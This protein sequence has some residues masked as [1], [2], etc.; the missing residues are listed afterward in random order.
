MIDDENDPFEEIVRQFFGENNGARP[1]A[2]RSKFVENEEESREIDF[3]E[4]D[5]KTFVVFELAGYRKEDV[6]VVVEDSEIIVVA[7]RKAEESVPGYL[8][9]KLNRGI[10]IKKTL[11][12]F[13]KNKKFTWTVKN[14]ILEVIFTK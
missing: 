11:P 3:L 6:R 4:T 7:R 9:E 10:E 8:S 13:L 2:R 5:D 14:G 1:R 12:K